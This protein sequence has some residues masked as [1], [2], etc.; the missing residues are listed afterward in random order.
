[1]KKWMKRPVI[2]IAALLLICVGAIAAGNGIRNLKPL[3]GATVE[4][5][6]GD[7][8][9]VSASGDVY[10]DAKKFKIT[11]TVSDG[12]YLAV[13]CKSNSGNAPVPDET[14]TYYMG[15]ADVSGG[16][17]NITTF[18][19]DMDDGKYVIAI[20]DL[21]NDGKLQT[22]A[23]FEVGSTSATAHK[24]GDVDNDGDPTPA[25]ATMI[26]KYYVGLLNEDWTQK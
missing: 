13:I 16:E 23:T 15:V 4:V 10:S 21:N 18:P 26:L 6:K 12:A 2:L 7:D 24:L 22:V 14:N 8:S 9:V 1:M 3:N 19:K 17:I 11:K 5:L 25:D 20:S